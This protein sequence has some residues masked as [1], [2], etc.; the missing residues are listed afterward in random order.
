VTAAPIATIRPHFPPSRSWESVRDPAA[1]PAPNTPGFVQGVLA[2]SYA[3]APSAA[4][5]PLETRVW[6]QR[7]VSALVEVIDGDR[8]PAQLA[9]WTTR[10]VFQ[11]VTRYSQ[12]AARTRIR[13]RAR[14]GREQ[15]AS[16]RVSQPAEG[17]MEVSARIR[18]G[19]RFRALAARIVAVEGGWQCTALQLG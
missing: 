14:T 3:P 17:A 4:D 8:P 6:A 18:C 19:D 15:V 11:S 2:L 16:V 7:F 9:R 5:G 13:R 12:A 1:L 10:P